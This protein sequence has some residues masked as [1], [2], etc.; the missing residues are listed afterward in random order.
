MALRTAGKLLIPLGKPKASHNIGH[1]NDLL[2][3][4]SFVSFGL[5]FPSFTL[6]VLFKIR[7]LQN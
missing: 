6:A 3:P 4:A 1:T 7:W 2:W 5:S